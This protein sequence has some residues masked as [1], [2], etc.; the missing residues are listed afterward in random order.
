MP[1][2]AAPTSPMSAMPGRT[3]SWRLVTRKAS[4]LRTRRGPRTGW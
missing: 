3:P 2:L 1:D 4:F